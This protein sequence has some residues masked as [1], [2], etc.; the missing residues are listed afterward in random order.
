M[1]AMFWLV[2]RLPEELVSVLPNLECSLEQWYNLVIR[3]EATI[4]N[5]N[6]LQRERRN[7]RRQQIFRCLGTRDYRQRNTREQLKL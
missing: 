4:R 1:F 7:Y 2:R 6:Y 3:L 5:V